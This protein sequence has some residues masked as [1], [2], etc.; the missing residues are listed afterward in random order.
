VILIYTSYLARIIQVIYDSRIKNDGHAKSAARIRCKIEMMSSIELPTLGF[1]P[2]VAC[3]T[4]RHITT[5][6]LRR[7]TDIPA[8]HRLQSSADDY[9]GCGTVA[10]NHHWR[11]RFAT[12][13]LQIWN[14]LPASV[15]AALSLMAFR[16]Q[17]TAHLFKQS[18]TS[19]SHN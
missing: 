9:L 14:G 12:A 5:S 13:A 16:R 15:K 17:L 10:L 4:R 19:L 1:I 6:Q 2:I 18:F 3:T 7:I 8:K 11:S